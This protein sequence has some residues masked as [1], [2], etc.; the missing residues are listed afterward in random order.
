MNA[1]LAAAGAKGHDH[2]T[3]RAQLRAELKDGTAS[4]PEILYEPEVPDY[5]WTIEVL[6]LVLMVPGQGKAT[7]PALLAKVPV[8]ESRRLGET[9]YR[10]RRAIRELL[11]KASRVGVEGDGRARTRYLVQS[12][13]PPKMQGVA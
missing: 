2:L 6:K 8:R 13:A 4:L 3:R 12:S 9:T 5:L 7:A 1:Q 10:Q 11:I